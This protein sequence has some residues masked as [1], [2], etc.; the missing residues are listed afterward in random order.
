M[1]FFVYKK[2]NPCIATRVAP[3]ISI[4]ININILSQNINRFK[5]KRKMRLY[6]IVSNVCKYL[7]FDNCIKRGFLKRNHIR[8]VLDLMTLV[9]TI[10]F[11]ENLFA[12][13]MVFDCIV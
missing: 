7:S 4:S 13:L 1:F 6:C 8:Y 9:H 10:L 11:L 2:S 5:L 12:I 3:L